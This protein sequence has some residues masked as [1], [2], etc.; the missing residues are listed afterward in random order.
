MGETV[1]G[2]G[3]GVGNGRGGGEGA[4]RAVEAAGAEGGR[5]EGEHSG[6]VSCGRKCKTSCW[7]FVAGAMS[8]R[9][10]TSNGTEYATRVAP[11]QILQETSHIGAPGH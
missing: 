2:W 10:E 11:Y 9:V 7:Y 4:E 3:G 8:S 5:F 6:S 1:G